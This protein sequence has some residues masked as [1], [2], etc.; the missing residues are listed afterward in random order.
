MITKKGLKNFSDEASKKSRW[1]FLM[2]I[3]IFLL[4]C[5]PKV[6][7]IDRQTLL[8]EQAAGEWPEFEKSLLPKV[9]HKNPVRF[10]QSP[11]NENEKSQRLYRVLQGEINAQKR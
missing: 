8:Y 11:A 5:S 7:I 9:I 6:Y 3:N 10:S 2:G 4:S 1:I